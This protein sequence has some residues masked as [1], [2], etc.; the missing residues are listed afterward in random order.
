L[1][2]SRAFLKTNDQAT[3]AR[4]AGFVAAMRESRARKSGPT[5]CVQFPKP[6]T[7]ESGSGIN[8]MSLLELSSVQT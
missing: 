5:A 8:S 1:S 3:D 2:W 4:I 7:I 6:P